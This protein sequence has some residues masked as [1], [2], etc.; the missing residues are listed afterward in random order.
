M[1]ITTNLSTNMKHVY[2]FLNIFVT[3]QMETYWM[4]NC[5]QTM[6][7][8]IR[9]NA[10]LCFWN[11]INVRQH[12]DLQISQKFN[13]GYKSSLYGEQG[14]LMGVKKQLNSNQNIY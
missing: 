1:V 10:I 12:L 8:F 7:Q 9:E 2:F 14:K 3:K 13:Y 5:V 6:Y 11:K 4:Y